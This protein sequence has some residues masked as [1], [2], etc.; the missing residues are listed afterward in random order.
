MV[1]KQHIQQKPD[2]EGMSLSWAASLPRDTSADGGGTRVRPI[3][4]ATRQAAAPVLSAGKGHAAKVG[5]QP[6]RASKETALRSGRADLLGAVGR[7]VFKGKDGT[8]KSCNCHCPSRTASSGKV[9]S[10]S[11]PPAQQ[12]SAPLASAKHWVGRPRR[13]VL[14]FLENNL[15]YINFSEGRL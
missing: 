6:T 15:K 4:G 7:L 14:R 13:R 11:R 10:S 12:L 3:P 2:S 5:G 8:A 1:G 9:S